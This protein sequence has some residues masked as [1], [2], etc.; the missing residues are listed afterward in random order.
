MSITIFA[1]LTW[2][3]ELGGAVDLPDR[4]RPRPNGAPIDC[5]FNHLILLWYLRR[6]SFR[7]CFTPRK[8]ISSAELPS[9]AA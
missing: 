9:L 5:T 1:I 2:S 7:T 8:T 4:G 3:A 6:R